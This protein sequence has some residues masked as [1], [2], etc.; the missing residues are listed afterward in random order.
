MWDSNFSK[1]VRW[2]FYIPIIL[3]ALTLLDLG[4]LYLT[5]LLLDFDWSFWKIVIFI[6][7]FGLLI[8]YFP[9]IVSTIISGLT[10]SFCPDRKIG[11]YIYSIFAVLNFIYLLFLMWTFEIEFTREAIATFVMSSIIILLTAG[12]S[13][14][15]ALMFSDDK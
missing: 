14:R 6:F 9:L 4:I 15:A 13:I 8:I 2:I 12:H 7:S 10:V 1:A 11:G 5:G 3:I